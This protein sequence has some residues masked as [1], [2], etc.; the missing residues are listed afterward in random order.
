LAA[1]SRALKREL[2]K[3]ISSKA[4]ERT[5]NVGHQFCGLDS[6]DLTGQTMVFYGTGILRFVLLNIVIGL[7]PPDSNLESHRP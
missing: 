2:V 7:L 1:S 6:A 4:L 5:V 3:Q